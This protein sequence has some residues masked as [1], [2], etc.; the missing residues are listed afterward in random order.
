VRRMSYIKAAL[1]VL[2]AAGRPMSASEVTA[3]A[4]RLALI[5]PAGRTPEQTMSAALYMNLEAGVGLIKHER[6]TRAARG[7]VRWS[8]GKE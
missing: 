3:E 4:V 5:T 1:V 8:V 7:G 2:R 6:P